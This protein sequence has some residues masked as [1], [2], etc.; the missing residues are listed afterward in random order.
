MKN[1]ELQDTIRATGTEH[2]IVWIV[3]PGTD[4]EEANSWCVGKVTFL[5]GTEPEDTIIEASP[6][7]PTIRVPELLTALAQFAPEG[8]VQVY[9][10]GWEAQHFAYFDIKEVRGDLDIVL[11]AWRCGG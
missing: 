11:G 5:N 8:D 2:G 4:G 9:V 3:N 10:E 6:N 7:G 1:R